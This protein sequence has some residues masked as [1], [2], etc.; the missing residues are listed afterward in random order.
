MNEIEFRIPQNCDLRNAEHVIER[1]SEDCG[2]NLALKGS[3]AKFP[4][5]THWHYKKKQ[6][7][8]T[9]ELTLYVRAR[10]ILFAT[11]PRPAI[12]RQAP[13]RFKSRLRRASPD[14]ILNQAE[15]SVLFSAVV[16]LSEVYLLITVLISPANAAHASAFPGSPGLTGMHPS[17]QR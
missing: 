3:L 13:L 12:R 16:P 1:V 17:R 14:F 2:L 9:L 8:G 5:C 11:N 4:G 10:R 15:P 6:Q 7:S